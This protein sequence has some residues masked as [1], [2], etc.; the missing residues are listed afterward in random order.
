MTSVDGKWALVTGA[1]SGLGADFA[2][3]LAARRCNLILVA[4]REDRLQ[5]LK[6][7]ILQASPVEVRVI[8][9]DLGI[10]NAAQD[11]YDRVAAEGINVDLL[12]NN[13]GFGQFGPFLD[14]DWQRDL[15]MLQL[16]IVNVVHLTKLFVRDMVKRG[17]GRVLQVASIGA[18]QPVPT[19]ASYAA[20]KAFLMHFSEALNYELRHTPVRITVL[21][22]GVTATEFLQVA[23]Q[24][25]TLFQ[26]LTMM[27]SRPVAEIGIHAML[28]GRANVIPGLLNWLLIFSLRFS[29]RSLMISTG[30]LVMKEPRG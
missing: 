22:P 26:R 29:P 7:E 20:S 1:S 27:Q 24:R 19:Y 15:S 28:R 17:F 2:R 18:F 13:A 30:H 11:L 6:Q 16:L 3:I 10:A 25:T 21:N 8:A 14:T 4:R 23:G 12:I 9:S 5:A